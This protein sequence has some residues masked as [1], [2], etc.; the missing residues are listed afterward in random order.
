MVGFA[1][2]QCPVNHTFTNFRESKKNYI[3]QVLIF[4]DDCLQ[5]ISWV[6]ILANGKMLSNIIANMLQ[7]LQILQIVFKKN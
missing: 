3:S 4:A 5:N 2:D 7:I 6:P 1:L